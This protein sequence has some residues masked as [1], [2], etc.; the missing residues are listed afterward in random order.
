VIAIIS[1]LVLWVSY[2]FWY[3]QSNPD[4]YAAGY[5]AVAL[6]LL[7][8]V[9]YL[10]KPTDGRLWA[11]GL[12]AALAM[13][14]HQGNLGF[15]GLIGLSLIWVASR[16]LPN[17]ALRVTW[18]QVALYAGICIVVVSG[19][20]AIGY[21]NAADALVQAGGSRPPFIGWVLGYF[22]KAEAGQATWGIS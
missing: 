10:K 8:Y 1:A 12:S 16:P 11:L 13:L 19:V 2:G 4:I 5:A 20:Y 3:F 18:K 6:L 21:F 17:D 22:N 15:A 14:A 9:R 7:A